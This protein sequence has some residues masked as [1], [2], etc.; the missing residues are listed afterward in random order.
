MTDLNDIE[1]ILKALA[2][3]K[4]LM[5]LDLLKDPTGNFPPQ[6]DGDLVE[7][8][9]CSNWLT[10]RMGVAQPTGTRHLHQ[11]ADAGLIVP[12]RKKGWV[13]YKRNEEKIAQIKALISEGL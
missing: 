8:G 1:N 3:D 5:V 6:V 9:V 7:D 4:R 13:F 11:L 12:T 10:E 2:S